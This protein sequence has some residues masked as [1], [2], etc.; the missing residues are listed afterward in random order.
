MCNNWKLCYMVIVFLRTNSHKFEFMNIFS[1]CQHCTK[2]NNNHLFLDNFFYNLSLK[3]ILWAATLLNYVNKLIK[4]SH[5]IVLLAVGMKDTRIKYFPKF[6][7]AV[8]SC[9]YIQRFPWIIKSVTTSYRL[10]NFFK[11]LTTSFFGAAS[12]FELEGIVTF[13]RLNTP[14]PLW[15]FSST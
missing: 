2:M 14:C 10:T 11:L 3:C 6:Q 12:S 9:K 4:W 1:I 13:Q 8:K 5:K 15:H 7:C